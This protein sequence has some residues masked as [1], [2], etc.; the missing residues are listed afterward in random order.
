MER[1]LH[2]IQISGDRLLKMINN[3]L[4]SAA[5]EANDGLDIASERVR[6]LPA[7][8]TREPLQLVSQAASSIQ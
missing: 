2:T 1:F 4:D 6:C 7:W 8:A 3:I 5:M